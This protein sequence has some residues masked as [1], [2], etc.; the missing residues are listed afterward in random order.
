MSKKN[1]INNR[2]FFDAIV[3]YKKKCRE[4]EDAGEEYPV[5]PDYICQCFMQIANR[6]STK[7]NFSG[8][9]FIDDMRMDG[10][11]NCIRYVKNFNPDKT[12]NPFAYFT[13]IIYYAFI[14]R[15][16]KEKEQLYIKYKSSTKL[17]AA[18]ETYHFEGEDTLYHKNDVEYMNNFVEDFEEKLEKDKEKRNAKSK[19]K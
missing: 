1:Y 16:T 17:I 8:Y 6:L 10:I 13:Q 2:D 18:G 9:S 5:V 3:E 7:P 4:A 12:E 19:S 15:I 11:E 14:R